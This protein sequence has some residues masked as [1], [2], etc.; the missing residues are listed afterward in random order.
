MLIRKFFNVACAKEVALKVAV[1]GNFVMRKK[2]SVHWQGD[3]LRTEV[4]NG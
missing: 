2:G 4:H 3:A 1:I